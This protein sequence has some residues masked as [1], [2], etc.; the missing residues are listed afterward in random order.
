MSFLKVRVLND[1]RESFGTSNSSA[2]EVMFRRP[3]V[4]EMFPGMEKNSLKIFASGRCTFLVYAY[5]FMN[6]GVLP[7]S[8]EKTS[9]TIAEACVSFSME[10]PKL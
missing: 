7:S 1:T 2:R 4:S 8:E 9:M 10:L 6:I 5:E 3:V